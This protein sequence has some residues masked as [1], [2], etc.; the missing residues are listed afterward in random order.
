MSDRRNLT[1][2]EANRLQELTHELETLAEQL[3]CRAVTFRA[4]QDT[5]LDQTA[6]DLRHVAAQ[7]F[8][9]VAGRPV[10]E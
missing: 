8:E 6:I 9:L 10:Y 3:R 2:E 5:E 4:I 1:A 7:V